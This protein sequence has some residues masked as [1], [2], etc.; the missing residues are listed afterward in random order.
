MPPLP[1]FC[2]PTGGERALAVDA[3]RTVNL[4]LH[5]LP[6][7]RGTYVLYGMPGLRPWAI[8]P[9]APIR[10][11][12]ETTTGR[13][14]AVA[15]STLYELFPGGTF[16]ALGAV[17]PGS[18]PVSMT[19]N[20]RHLVLSSSEVGYTYDLQVEALAPIPPTGPSRFGQVAYL[21]GFIVTNE[22]GTARFWSSGLF[23]AETWD[24]LAFYV[25]EGRGDPL[26]TLF[27]D[28]REL[29]LF[30]T[31]T[32]EVWGT[33]GVSL[34]PFARLSSVFIEQGMAAPHAT[35][36]S[37]NALYWLGGSARGQG[38]IFRLQ[39]YTPERISTAAIETAMGRMPL[40][41]DAV[42]FSASLG[43]HAWVGWWFPSGQQ[44]WLFD[45]TAQAWTQLAELE[46]DGNLSAW[47]AVTH[48]YSAGRHLWGDRRSGEL[49]VWDEAYYRYGTDAL[50]RERTTPHLRRDQQPVRY[51]A[52]ELV[53]QA[54]V[55]LDAGAEPGK[56]PQVMLSYSDDGGAA[57][58]YPR[59]RSC[60]PLGRRERR[61][62]WRQLGQ[63]RATRCFRVS[64]TDPVP[65]AWMGA[66]VE[67]A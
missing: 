12:F 13:T 59:V 25:A 5:E 10:G 18:A 50:Y 23:D 38:P 29:Y 9:D 7:E 57:W 28:H 37:N 20:G 64:M 27:V 33:T 61:V 24:P 53:C 63:A 67:V 17:A 41:G 52:F 44:T 6:N 60:G 49:Y 47:R 66:H 55:G 58:S 4:Y 34:A 54:G 2:G 14:F 46:P 39:G 3:S 35:V 16:V 21:D 22:P 62:I 36:A 42:A 45:T 31:Q 65:T 56:D 30:G 43:G 19:D 15:G 11:L 8:L 26:V 32:T 1:L 40:V 48:A 51:A